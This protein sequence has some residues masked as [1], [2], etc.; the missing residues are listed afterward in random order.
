MAIWI[1]SILLVHNSTKRLYLDSIGAFIIT[2]FIF[3]E[4]RKKCVQE[5]GYSLSDLKY[6]TRGIDFLYD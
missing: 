2:S 1:I 3:D 4:L 5:R 6:I